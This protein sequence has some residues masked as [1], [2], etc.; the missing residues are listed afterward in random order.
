M[1]LHKMINETHK[2][3][4]PALFL[5]IKNT[6]GNSIVTLAQQHYGLENVASHDDF[7]VSHDR[8]KKD[9]KED[10]ELDLAVKSAGEYSHIP[11]VSGYFD[12]DYAKPLFSG[13]F[14]FTFLREPI[15]R[16]LSFYYFCKTRNPNQY[17]IYA[18]AHRVSLTDFLHLGFSNPE[19]R[20][21][22]WNNQTA[23]LSRGVGDSNQS[24]SPKEL[25]S[26]ATDH[27]DAFS[28]IGFAETF[29]KDRDYVL[30]ALGIPIPTSRVMATV[31]PLRPV[32]NELPKVARDLLYELT[33]LDRQLYEIAW[34]KRNVAARCYIEL[35]SKNTSNDSTTSSVEITRDYYLGLLQQCLTGT[36]YGDA[37]F[38]PF[39]SREFD[40][41]V[42]ERGLDWSER[43]QTMIGD[44]RL[45]NLRELV[46]DLLER[47]VPGDLI[48]TGVWRGGSCILMRAILLAY[49]DAH[50]K[51]WVADSFAGLPPGNES[52][53]PADAGS[54][55]HRYAELSVSLEEVKQNFADYGL[56][57]DQVTFL[58]GWFRDTLPTAPIDRLALIRLDGDMYESTIDALKALYPRVSHKGYIIIDDYHVVPAC[59]Q[60]VHDYCSSI[61]I[62]PQLCEIDGVGVYWKKIVPDTEPITAISGPTETSSETLLYRLNLALDYLNRMVIKQLLFSITKRDASLAKQQLQ[63]ADLNQQVTQEK[64]SVQ[65]LTQ[66]IAEE[67]ASVEALAQQ[68]AGEKVLVEALTRQVE[69]DANTIAEI[70]ASPS[71]KVTHPLRVLNTLLRRLIQRK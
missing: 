2:S 43:A 53:Y 30:Q 36:L 62:T 60:A 65:A 5:R 56:L 12:F 51:V 6:V 34:A 69:N 27:L 52:L 44:K 13:R 26:L 33:D 31:K 11:F 28:H 22:I 35:A 38:A 40:P 42:R 16:I 3:Y 55:F 57:D 25:L 54:E 70:R 17:D 71:W 49:G 61:G 18:L 67:R 23:Q 29:E 32:L 50:R 47:N 48:E 8:F 10:I 66:Q 68:I 21:F 19:V 59:K 37:S 64:A 1:W 24:L 63:I 39:G 9:R 7:I 20:A 46:S 45:A 14:S 58:K 41:K 4:R 15:E